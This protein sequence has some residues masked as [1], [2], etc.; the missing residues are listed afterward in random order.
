MSIAINL[1]SDIPCS[2]SLFYLHRQHICNLNY[3]QFYTL[4]YNFKHSGICIALFISEEISIMKYLLR[5]GVSTLV[6]ENF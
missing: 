3:L 6:V 4:T 2:F 5:N 1:T